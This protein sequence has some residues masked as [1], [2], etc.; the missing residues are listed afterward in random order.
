AADVR[1]RYRVTALLRQLKPGLPLV[2]AARIQDQHTA[3]WHL[4]ISSRSLTGDFLEVAYRMA[5]GQLPRADDFFLEGDMGAATLDGVRL[6]LKRSSLEWALERLHRDPALLDYVQ[7]A[8]PR[9]FQRPGAVR[10]RA[11]PPFPPPG[12]TAPP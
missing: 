5:A 1:E 3:N 6:S 4:M 9:G 2:H 7:L 8:V 11:R 10:P 12:E